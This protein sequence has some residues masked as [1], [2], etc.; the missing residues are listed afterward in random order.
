MKLPLR[1]MP[2]AVLFSL[3]LS[4]CGGG[5]SSA[6]NISV[7]ASVNGTISGL[8]SIIVNGVRY[9]T[10]G[11][12]V[13]DA[14][15]R[16]SFSAQ[17]GLGMTVVVDPSATSSTSASTIL[18]QS[19]IRGTTSSTT[20]TGTTLNFNVA[21][22]P[23]T[24]D[25]S[26]L[27]VR[28]TGTI[29]VLA[30]VA[31]SL[32]VEIYGLPQADGTFKATRIEVETTPEAIRLVGVVSNLN[33]ANQT[34][35]MGTGSNTVAV[36]YS[37]LTAPTGLTNGAVVSVRTAVTTTSATYTA[38]GL[39]VRATDAATFAQ[40]ATNYRGTTGVETEENELYGV[41]ANWQQPTGPG[42]ACTF[43]VQGIPVSVS[44]GTLCDAIKDGDYVEAKGLLSNGTLTAYRVEFKTSDGRPLV[45]YH[46]DSSD[47][48]H[49][50]LK[51]TNIVSGTT[52]GTGSYEVYGTLSSCTPV[53]T[54]TS[55]SLT[56][57]GT[58]YTADLSTAVWEHGAV[59]SGL[60]EAKG[61][62]TAPDAFKVTKI[63]SK[64]H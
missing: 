31:D 1:V 21:G 17:L 43:Q 37:G 32:N 45:G 12:S 39:Y 56:V 35:S 41:V 16:T 25:T 63:E 11:A 24:A 40:Y 7:P 64:S 62:M 26:T 36:A 61:Y 53:G 30:D 27:V 47:S 49:D 54:P 19:G 51:Y 48:D 23:V 44:S 4:A 3:V 6:P 29:G 57:N 18:V 42:T 10:I 14:D 20:R 2:T 22:L 50:D 33:T 8:G 5:G 55:C 60:V 52:A 38:T 28:S 13:L 9:E 46:D 59:T 15:D 34:F 58:T